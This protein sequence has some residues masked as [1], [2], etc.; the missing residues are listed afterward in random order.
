VKCNAD[1]L[2]RYSSFSTWL[3]ASNLTLTKLLVDEDDVEMGIKPLK[4]V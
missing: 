2:K 3:L 1:I 4:K